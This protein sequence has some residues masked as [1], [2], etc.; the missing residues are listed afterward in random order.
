[1]KHISLTSF[2]AILAATS[3]PTTAAADLKDG[4][5]GGVVGGAV[6]AIITNEVQKKN[7]AAAPKQQT[8]RRVVTK[9][10]A[11]SL[12]SQ[13]TRDERVQIQLALQQ[14]GFA[15]GTIDGIIGRNSRAAIGQFQVSMG[16]PQT[17]Q[18]TRA[19]YVLLT[20]PNL[21]AQQQQAFFD[22]PLN[23]TEVV[24]LQS[25]LR[26][27]GFYPGIVDGVT[28]PGTRNAA[29]NFLI[30]QG[31]N[32]AATT[33]VQTLVLSSL[34]AG[35]PVQPY[36]QQEANAQL[37]SANA[38]Q[39]FGNQGFGAQQNAFGAQPQQQNGFIGQPQQQ[40]NA[41]F[42]AQQQPGVAGF[43]AQ[44]QNGF[45]GQ[46]QQQQNAFAQPQQQQQNGFVGQQPLQQQNAFG[47]QGGQQAPQQQLFPQT[48]PQTPAPQAQG[49]TV[50]VNNQ[51]QS[52]FDV[53]TGTSEQ[54]NGVVQQQPGAAA[55]GQQPL[56]DGG[57]TGTAG[58]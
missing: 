38:Q 37:A 58:N 39:Q 24:Q 31:R 36:L 47:A 3:V 11:P 12:N 45:V 25:G 9:Q 43:G 22:R 54:Q 6:G 42:G 48:N 55:S 16:Q 18:L 52:S 28:G 44:Q 26:V 14:R 23:Q 7:R 33:Q 17:G 57:V 40:Q 30:S 34:A 41:G 32:P 21:G 15:I 46:P 8:T 50:L 4:L 49:G 29:G 27:L 1:M 10:A 51:P 53:F 5:I 13:Y 2:V 35:I 19:Q 56:I 20:N